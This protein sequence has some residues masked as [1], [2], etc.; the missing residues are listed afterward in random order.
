VAKGESARHLGVADQARADDLVDGAQ[1]LVV[2]RLGDLRC[3][4]ELERVT[5]ERGRL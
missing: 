2:R 3:Q 5:G 1:R 4:V